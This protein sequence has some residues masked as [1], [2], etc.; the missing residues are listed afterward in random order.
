[1]RHLDMRY[2][3]IKDIVSRGNLQIEHC[4]TEIMIVDFLT[5]PLQGKMFLNVRN[6]ILGPQ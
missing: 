1:M 5:K 2:Y 4:P 3:F 6:Q